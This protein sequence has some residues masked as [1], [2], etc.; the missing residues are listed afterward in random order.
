MN[1]IR[2][3]QRVVANSNCDAMLITG[4]SNRRYATGFRSTAGKVLVTKDE[5]LFFIDSRYIEAAEEQIK[6]CRVMEVGKRSDYILR[7]NEAMKEHGLSR[8][9]FE[10]QVVTVS[11]YNWFSENLEAEL[12]PC[13]ELLTGLR[14]VKSADELELMKKAQSIA[15]RAFEQVLGIISTDITETQLAAELTHRM[16]M[17]GAEGCSFEPII[18]SGD[19]SSIP[20]GEA[21]D[22][23]LKNGFLIMDFG[24]RYKGYCSDT[25]RTLCI[26]KPT[27]EMRK[28]YDTVLEA[29]LAGIAAAKAGVTG[30][31]ID[32]AARDVINANGYKGA[33]GH[34]FGHSLG[35]DIHENPNAAPGVKEIIPK[36]AV[37]SAEPGIYLKGKF[38]VR[39]E[40][41]LYITENGSE[42]I[43]N[44]RKDLIIL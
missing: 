27:E 21:E 17:L 43:T 28:V 1:K 23:K 5:A 14:S 22:V 44:L 38:G 15:E 3:I 16:M 26:G 8:L 30:E 2:D 10:Y 37:I 9:G 40:D 41:V 36:G 32:K 13:Q 7:I 34:A 29:Q 18:V 33:F 20:H 42:D 25:T 11:D 12:I 6:D 39:I 35:L 31:S 24:A 4:P 19:H